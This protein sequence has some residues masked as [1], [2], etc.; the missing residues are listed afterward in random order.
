[1]LLKVGLL[2]EEAGALEHDVYAELSPGELLGIGV[3]V[4]ADR[5]AVYVDA[6]LA[7]ADGIG[8]LI[9]LLGGIVLEKM[10]EHGGI[11]KVVDGDYLITLRAE[12]LPE[13]QASDPAETVDSNF[14]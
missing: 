8:V 14:Y 13:R 12:H 3:L 1:M 5:S 2:G 9:T 4:D 11:G 10:S 7:G 6:V